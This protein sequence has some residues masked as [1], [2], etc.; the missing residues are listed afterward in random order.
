VGDDRPTGGFETAPERRRGPQH[1]R[2]TLPALIALAGLV[3]LG[4]VLGVATSMGDKGGDASPPIG[5]GGGAPPPDTSNTVGN[6][7][8]E[9]AEFSLVIRRSGN[10]ECYSFYADGRV[11]LRVVGVPDVKDIGMVSGDD[12]AGK[13]NWESGRQSSYERDGETLYVDDTPG[14]IIEKCPP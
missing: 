12:T 13:I 6:P 9:D 2:A 7:P 10:V 4:T 14:A 1:H 8:G 5:G 11:E 3:T